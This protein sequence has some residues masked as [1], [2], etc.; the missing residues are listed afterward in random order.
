M[1][2]SHKLKGQRHEIGITE[3]MFDKGEPK[4]I[5]GLAQRI[6]IKGTVP[7]NWIQQ[8]RETKRRC[9]ATQIMGFV[10]TVLRDMT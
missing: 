7:R 1:P 6:Q 10:T 8:E 5:P 2:S 4:K 9:A 3:Y